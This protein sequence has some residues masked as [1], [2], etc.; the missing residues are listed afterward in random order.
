LSGVME[1]MDNT[2]PEF[3]VP[4]KLVD[5][6]TDKNYGAYANANGTMPVCFLT[7]NDITGGNSGSPVINA[8][9]ELI[10]AAFDGNWE[11][12]SGDIFF[13]QNIQR[14]IVVDI[15][16]VLFIVDK[17]AGA[18]NLIEEMELVRTPS[19]VSSIQAAPMAPVEKDAV[20]KT[21]K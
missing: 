11:A 13:E 10:G 2:N 16:Y 7:N 15:R 3:V 21:A 6:Y 20:L 19:A 18:T 17:Y 5:L 12:M 9:G 8:R 14:T 1:K 4:Q